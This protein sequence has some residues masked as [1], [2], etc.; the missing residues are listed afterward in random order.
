MITWHKKRNQLHFVESSYAEVGDVAL[1]IDPYGVFWDNSWPYHIR[2][3]VVDNSS[4]HIRY[5][6]QKDIFNNRW[7]TSVML[8][9][10]MATISQTN[11]DKIVADHRRLP[12]QEFCLY[13]AKIISDNYRKLRKTK[14]YL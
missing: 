12:S 14:K 2:L 13:L 4:P 11:Y 7:Y 5:I 1:L 3:L 10:S 8:L 6:T 9:P